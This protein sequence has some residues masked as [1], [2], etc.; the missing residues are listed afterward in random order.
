MPEMCWLSSSNDYLIYF[1]K[2]SVS[3]IFILADKVGFINNML[4]QFIYTSLIFTVCITSASCAAVRQDDI[5]SKPSNSVEKKSD[6]K[7]EDEEKLSANLS[8]DKD[9]DN[10][11]RKSS[12]DKRNDLLSDSSDEPQKQGF[13][14]RCGWYSNPTPG[15]H[16]LEDKD[17]EWILG[18][19]GGHQAEGDYPP[20]FT[21]SQWM[22]T[23]GFYGYGCACLSVKVDKKEG[24]VLEVAGAKAHPLSACQ[25]D[26]AL[27]NPSE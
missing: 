14:L 6:S 9:T 7:K 13:E 5:A 12:E 15:N 3:R 27:R 21:I 16:W 23:N 11:E 1:K 24:L 20:E 17:G 19:Q 18:V 8:E 10:T 2:S 26:P 4:K 25:N 22:A